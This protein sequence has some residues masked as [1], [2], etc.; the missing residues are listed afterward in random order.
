MTDLV[1]A[2]PVFLDLTFVG[3][4][5]LPALGEERFA[6]ELLRSPGGGA[7]TA[8]AAARLGLSAAVAAPLGDDVGGDLVRTMLTEEGVRCI[9]TRP[10]PRTPTTMVMPF[11]GDRAMV[12]IDP[13]ARATAADVAAMEP[14]AVA[15]S[16]DQLYVVPDVTT[17]YITCGDDDLRAYEGRPPGALAGARAL[18]VNQR[19]ALGLSGKDDI[20][21][22]ATRLAEL[23]ETVIVTLAAEG[24]MAATNGA[25]FTAAAERVERPADTTGAGDVLAAA[26][27]W[28]DLR[29]AEPEDRLRWAVLYAG[30]AVS[31]PTGVGGAV[32]EAT[33]LAGR[34]G[35]RAHAA[36]AR[37]LRLSASPVARSKK[38]SWRWS[39]ASSS[40]SPGTTRRRPS[41]AAQNR[42][43][44]SSASSVASSSDTAS[45]AARVASV[46]TRGASTGKRTLVTPPSSS[47]RSGRTTMRGS[48]A[49][50]SSAC[51][52]SVGR[53]PRMTSPAPGSTGTSGA[54]GRLNPANETRPS[55]HGG[56]DHVHRRRPDEG[57]DEEVRRVV[58]E[59][60]RRVALLQDAVAEDGHPL[61]ERHRLDL[62]VRHVDGRHAEPLVQARQLG[63]HRDAELRVEVRERLVHEERLWLAHH[64]PSHGD[65]LALAAGEERGAPVEQR[66]E[67]E[68]RRNPPHAARAL[69][70]R[71]APEL[72]P[73][74][75]VLL[76]AHRRVQRVVLEHHRDVAV[77]GP[78]VGDVLVADH[79]PALRHLLQPGDHPQE[80]RLPAAGRADEDHELAVLDVERDRIESLDPVWIDLRG[81]LEP[82]AAHVSSAD[83]G[84]RRAARAA[85]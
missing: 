67:P 5:S 18:F 78:Q 10:A 16:L 79:D 3:L 4:E 76:H 15:S 56:L 12:T 77:A 75:E 66:L 21:D 44:R 9:A 22:A 63:A 48:S 60:L 51:R 42:A 61:A 39:T 19:E 64:R 49:G 65:T 24:A 14:R 11:G 45:I 52:R 36:A 17:A 31:T 35:A 73:E 74:A 50:A 47:T 20:A 69:R 81:V 26:Y 57:G 84:R 55:P 23:A 7:I 28:A 32:D 8:V 80:R 70:P 46:S 40:S 33:L 82:D 43:R 13:G 30:L 38:W 37:G 27:I 41:T 68:R 1:V 59:P 29:G 85:R 58:E 71:D 2:T 34:R 62:V 6:A 72:Q 25:T 53:I 83:P 54:S